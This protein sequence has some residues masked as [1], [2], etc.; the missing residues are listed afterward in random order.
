M[1][2]TYPIRVNPRKSASSIRVKSASNRQRGAT[3]PSPLHFWHQRHEKNI[4]HPRKSAL[5]PRKSASSIR[6]KSASSSASPIRVNPRP[7][8]ALN[9]RQI[10]NVGRRARR[11]YIFGINAMKKTYPIR[12]NP[13][14]IRVHPRPPSASSIRVKSASNR[15]RGATCPSPLHFWH[16]RH[17]KNISHPRK[18]ALHPRSSASSSA[19]SIRVKSASNRQRGA[20]CP[21]P[22][23]FWHQRH[24][25]T[26]PIRVNPRPPS[27]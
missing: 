26:Y 10:G 6:V 8:S 1:K 16:Q 19:S 21:S 11:P 13:R 27:A 4:S 12:V 7:P 3:C 14:Y 9:P 17:E 23:H 24:E 18:S 20:T 22:L 25:K 2:K 15:Q 5:N